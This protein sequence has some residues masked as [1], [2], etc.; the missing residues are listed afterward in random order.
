VS[1]LPADLLV[2]DDSAANRVVLD[3][4]LTRHGYG[5]TTAADGQETLRLLERRAFSL[6][7]LDIEMPGLNGLDVLRTIR[8]R[9][10]PSELPVIMVTARI[11]SH[12]IVEAL[13]LGAND[14]LTKPVDFAVAA[15]RIQTQLALKQAHA[16]LRQSEE[17]YALAAGGARDGIWDWD[18]AAGQMYF[19]PRWKA[20]LG[21]GDDE[22]LPRPEEWFTRV[23]PDD[24]QRLS[25][26][27]EAHVGGHTPHFEHEHRMRHRDGS[28][29]WMLSRGL[30]VQDADGRAYRMAGSLTDVTESKVSDALTGL[31]NRTLFIDRVRGALERGRG[32]GDS[33]A[34]AVLFL[35]LDRFRVINESFGYA[36]G[37]HLLLEVAG[38]L[39]ACMRAEYAR[40]SAPRDYTIA[41]LTGDEF[42][43]LLEDLSHPGD[44]IR[45]VQR[46]EAALAEP[47]VID[48][49]DVYATATVGVAVR[50]A[51]SDGLDRPDALLR[52]ANTAMHRAKALGLARHEVFDVEMHQAAVARLR[53][54]SDLRRAIERDE[55]RVFY[56]PIVSLQSGCIEGVE[57]LVRWSHPTRGLVLPTEFIPIAEEIGLILPIGAW[58]LRQTCRQAA[59]WHA[60]VGDDVSFTVGVNVSSRQFLGP[61]LA[62]L[63]ERTLEETQLPAWRLKLEITESTIIE[64]PDAVTAALVQLRSLGVQIAI[65]D[66]GTGYS[67]L[68]SLHQLPID[69]L[70]IDRSFIER[71]NADG[72]EIVRAIVAMARN[73]GLSVTAE[74]VE[75]EDQLTQLKHLGCAEAQGYLFAPPLDADVAAVLSLREPVLQYAVRVRHGSTR[76]TLA[77]TRPALV[78]GSVAAAG[79]RRG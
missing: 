30:A 57:A 37:D 72:A 63:I 52:E 34:L 62:G 22:L 60:A 16:A 5:V 13:G 59:S 17:R 26:A 11:Q 35:D 31:P 23:H 40:T 70:K 56:Q 54:E 32:P 45:A 14:Y 69:T 55:L 8:Q 28:C 51:R 79:G 74:G 6:I 43:I 65:D 10:S 41:R 53:L 76:R 50:T 7:L 24:V 21:Y 77:A 67:S 49:D 73:L 58:V 38:R 64:N 1:H 15:A 78:G 9:H 47:F 48:G 68:S 27:I 19:S 3:R 18:L 20:M 25:A 75:T 2:V 33:A 46:I 66:F 12:Q 71:M 36:V 61:D 39:D 4:Q 44:A 42:A 29:R